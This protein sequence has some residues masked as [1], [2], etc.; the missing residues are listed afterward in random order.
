MELVTKDHLEVRVTLRCPA[1][2][3]R[4][5]DCDLLSCSLS[6]TLSLSLSLSPYPLHLFPLPSYLH[7]L[8]GSA[9]PS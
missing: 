6:L 9:S 1:Q 7:C 5:S 4:D 3:G 2:V 8:E